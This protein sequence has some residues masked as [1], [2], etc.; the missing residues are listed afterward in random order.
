MA[1]PVRHQP[2]SDEEFLEHLLQHMPQFTRDDLLEVLA[3]LRL[4]TDAARVRAR[5]LANRQPPQA[6]WS[7]RSRETLVRWPF[8][9]DTAPNLSGRPRRVDRAV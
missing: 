1:D 5:A 3:A 9:L 6:A 7:A 8:G 2:L 4:G